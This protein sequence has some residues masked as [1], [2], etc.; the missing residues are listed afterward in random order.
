[1]K[2]E[3][4]EWRNKRTE[5]TPAEFFS[6]IKEAMEGY[7][8][9]LCLESDD[10]ISYTAKTIPQEL[11]TDDRELKR[12]PLDMKIEAIYRTEHCSVAYDCSGHGQHFGASSPLKTHDDL[13]KMESC[14]GL[15]YLNRRDYEQLKLF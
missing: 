12:Y 9:N 14:L 13:E 5:F 4:V 7:D 11:F 15:E 3:Q 10:R 1:M 2:H 8:A 6:K